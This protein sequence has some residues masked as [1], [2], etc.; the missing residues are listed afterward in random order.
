MRSRRPSQPS[1]GLAFT[2]LQRR[3]TR[4]QI[5]PRV[6][7]AWRSLAALMAC[8]AKCPRRQQPRLRSQP[9]A[10][11]SVGNPDLA[12]IA[13]P[14]LA[15]DDAKESDEDRSARVAVGPVRW[16]VHEVLDRVMIL[17]SS[18]KAMHKE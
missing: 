2:Y 14:Y 6:T 9:S 4:R 18:L 3:Y 8:S 1:E 17:Q 15:A 10:A 11:C 12:R 5:S 13:S 16:F 7:T